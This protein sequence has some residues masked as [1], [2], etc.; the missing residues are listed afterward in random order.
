MV[1]QAQTFEGIVMSRQNYRES[2]MLVKIL[3]DQFG[4]KMFL[5]NRARKPGFTLAAGILPF[6]HADYIGEIRE[7]GLSYL[8]AIKNAK[9]YRQISTDITLNAYASYI[10]GLLDLAYPDGQPVGFWF[11]QIKQALHLIDTG[12]DPQ[13]IA[14]VIEVQ[15]LK[16]YGVEPNW[17]GCVID[18][19][20][21]LPL[22]FSESYGG[23]L[24]QRHWDKD[25]HRLHA[26]ARAI[27]YL[28]RFS[29]LNLDQVKRI[30]VKPAT[31]AELK[32]ILDVIYT[33]MVGV[34][35]KAK[36]FIDQMN[37]WQDR[38]PDAHQPNESQSDNEHRE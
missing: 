17:R 33:D 9:Q 16:A 30:D 15:M 2:D 7:S 36:R 31:K 5:L 26:S 3:T 24:C 4:K 38:L 13:I 37:H 11:S 19:R 25:P 32:R 10:F 20:T 35:P 28:R 34:T 22:D 29:T 23:L 12:L 1:K 6:T 14:N 27:F 21:D 18:G 8:S